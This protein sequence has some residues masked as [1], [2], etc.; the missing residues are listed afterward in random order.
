MA[1]VAHIKIGSYAFDLVLLTSVGSENTNNGKA[2]LMK[3][4][5]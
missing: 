3:P 1:L 5:L 2:K 4:F